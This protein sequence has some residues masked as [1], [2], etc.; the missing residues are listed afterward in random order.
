MTKDEIF[1]KIDMMEIREKDYP[2]IVYLMEALEPKLFLKIFEEI[3]EGN[4]VWS[5]FERFLNI[6][7]DSE[8]LANTIDNQESLSQTL[9]KIYKLRESLSLDHPEISKLA[10]N[11]KDSESEFRDS[12]LYEL[13]KKNPNDNA[14]TEFLRSKFFNAIINGKVITSNNIPTSEVSGIFYLNG[15]DILLTINE[16]ILPISYHFQELDGMD[17]QY[18][19]ENNIS[20]DLMKKIKSIS[21]YIRV[22][23]GGNLND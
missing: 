2:I 1:K 3:L 21:N 12:I 16:Y 6:Y 9:V 11:T 13:S 22:L 5:D 10:S 20:S 14:T 4:L 18:M 15:N 8:L 7:G 23:E 19:S 17:Y